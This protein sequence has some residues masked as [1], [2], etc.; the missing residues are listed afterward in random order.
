MNTSLKS[1]LLALL[2]CAL[3]GSLFPCIK[4]G[5]AAL[6]IDPQDI[7]SILL[8]AGLRFLVC[9]LLLGGGIAVRAKKIS[10]PSA[11]CWKYIAA[12]GTL[13]VVLHYALTYIALSSV[14]GGKA[15]ILK[16]VGFLL[17]PCFAFL[18]RRED[19][20]SVYKVLGACLGF[21]AVIVVNL[22]GLQLTFGLGELFCIGASFCLSAS[23]VIAK[24]AYERHA[25][26]Y[27]LAHGQFFGGA[28]LTLFGLMLGGH[29]SRFDLRGALVLVYICFA[30]I[31]AYLLWETL[32]KQCDM[33]RLSIIK[34]TEPLFAVLFS[35]LLL[36]EQV[37]KPATLVAVALV[38]GAVLLGS[39][40]DRCHRQKNH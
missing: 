17:L 2:T 1:L 22:E 21:A 7:P 33:S 36:G 20:F 27:V 11:D 12:T 40:A 38:V 30:S 29:F 34:S 9:G 19:C 4:L 13:G 31:T 37:L 15:S 10:L 3:W 5:Y 24:K 14:E 32:L 25:P 26:A 35:G 23:T 18:F 28:V 8:F 6:A 39:C 16:Q